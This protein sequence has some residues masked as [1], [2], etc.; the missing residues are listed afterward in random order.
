[1]SSPLSMFS[2]F[3]NGLVGVHCRWFVELTTCTIGSCLHNKQGET[4]KMDWK[5]LLKIGR[6]PISP[7]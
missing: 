1:M 2:S 6:V 4:V 3:R 7:I 5:V